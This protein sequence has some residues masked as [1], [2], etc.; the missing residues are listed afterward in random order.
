MKLKE[1]MFIDIEDNPSEKLPWKGNVD[2]TAGKELRKMIV[3]YDAI[4]PYYEEIPYGQGREG[5]RPP[6]EWKVTKD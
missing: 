5:F 2:E 1:D 4:K 3:E 6:F